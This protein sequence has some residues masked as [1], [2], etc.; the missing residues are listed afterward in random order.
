MLNLKNKKQRRTCSLF[1]GDRKFMKGPLEDLKCPKRHQHQI[2][3][4]DTN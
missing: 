1:Y 2:Q 4:S 3:Y